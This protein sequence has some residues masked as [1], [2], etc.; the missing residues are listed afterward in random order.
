V[1]ALDAGGVMG[2]GG[3]LPVDVKSLGKELRR[4]WENTPEAKG[5]NHAV[6]TRA[7]TR[8]LV[9]LAAGE[10]E[11]AHAADVIARVADRHPTRAFLVREDAMPDRLAAFL[12]AR[13]LLRGGGR[14]VCCEQITLAVGPTARR[15]AAGAI[16]P[17][18][19]PD[20]PVFVW[21]LG[22]VRWD[23]ELLR[24]LLTV[25]DRLVVDSRAVLDAHAL[26]KELAR[27]DT[28]RTWAPGD[29]EWSRL[30]AWREAIAA[31]F[32]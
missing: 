18:L 4:L 25:T 17:L 30:G 2:G 9:V 6:L 19:V 5:P 28:G 22:D 3:A 21:V 27:T 31:Q 23:D 7:C 15:R 29:L 32:D 12:E 13:C 14:H 8:N 10:V 11:A 16:V 26:A 1:S 24:H 20:L